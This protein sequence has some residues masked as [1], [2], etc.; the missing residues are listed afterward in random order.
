MMGEAV[1]SWPRTACAPASSRV[2]LEGDGIRSD[3]PA[4]TWRPSRPS[5]V[6]S[7]RLA[8][9]G[10]RVS[11]GWDRENMQQYKAEIPILGKRE[12]NTTVGR[13]VDTIHYRGRMDTKGA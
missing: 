11:R 3:R 2:Q 1:P 6:A 13:G 12:S 9:P 7:G 4:P 10:F 8:R 5:F